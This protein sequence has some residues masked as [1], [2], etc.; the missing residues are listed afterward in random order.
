[1]LTNTS[2]HFYVRKTRSKRRGTLV[3][4]PPTRGDALRGGCESDIKHKITAIFHKIG[5]FVSFVFLYISA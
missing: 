1:M 5:S 3:R 4:T 2:P